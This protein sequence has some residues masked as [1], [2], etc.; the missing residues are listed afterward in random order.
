VDCAKSASARSTSA[1]GSSGVLTALLFALLP[2]AFQKG[3]AL[4]LMSQ[5]GIMRSSSR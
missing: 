3:F 2:L 1:A 5:M 4:T